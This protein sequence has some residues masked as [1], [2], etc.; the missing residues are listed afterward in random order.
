MDLR[1]SLEV[2]IFKK[3]SGSIIETKLPKLESNA[4][5]IAIKIIGRCMFLIFNLLVSHRDI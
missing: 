2:S 5:A 1:L 4:T 3:V